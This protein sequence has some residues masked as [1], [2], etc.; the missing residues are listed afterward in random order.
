MLLSTY[1]GAKLDCNAVALNSPAIDVKLPDLMSILS[2]EAKET[3]D[4]NW[5]TS[6]TTGGLVI[7]VIA[8]LITFT[9]S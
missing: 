2:L 7:V 1:A 8:S 3:F 5:L 4:F 6:S 9:S